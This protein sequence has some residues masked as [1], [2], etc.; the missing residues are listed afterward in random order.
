MERVGDEQNPL[1]LSERSAQTGNTR[2][3]LVTSRDAA[4]LDRRE[5]S[6]LFSQ[7]VITQHVKLLFS[8][9]PPQDVRVCACAALPAEEPDHVV[10][11]VVQV[12]AA[13]RRG[14]GHQQEP[15]LHL[16]RT[17]LRTHRKLAVTSATSQ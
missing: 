17:R 9:L 1:H 10:L 3:G 8:P 12:P 11:T 4:E 13:M 5:E 15:H 6:E 2:Q 16:V 7:L 14:V